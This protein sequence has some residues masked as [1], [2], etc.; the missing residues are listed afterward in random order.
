MTA[1]TCAF[2]TAIDKWEMQNTSKSLHMNAAV[3]RGIFASFSTAKLS[4]LYYIF[5]SANPELRILNVFDL[6]S[7][8]MR[9]LGPE[10]IQMS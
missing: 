8:S 7:L 6:L 4:Y 9:I 2:G 5:Y 1:F 10:V 3:R